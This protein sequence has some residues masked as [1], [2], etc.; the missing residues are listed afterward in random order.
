MMT[1]RRSLEEALL[2]GL[3]ELVIG[4]A[5]VVEVGEFM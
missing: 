3:L 2:T 5:L 4:F 1:A